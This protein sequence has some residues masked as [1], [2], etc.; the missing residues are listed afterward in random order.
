[1]LQ[2][3][4]AEIERNIGTRGGGGQM[5]MGWGQTGAGPDGRA[6]VGV[7]GSSSRMGDRQGCGKT[8]ARDRGGWVEAYLVTHSPYPIPD[9]WYRRGQDWVS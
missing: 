6:G 3:T 9:R 4:Q 7:D 5:G 1:M 2:I 8:G